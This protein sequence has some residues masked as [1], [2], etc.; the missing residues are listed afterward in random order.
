[1][2]HAEGQ[3]A[4][5]ENS[6]F[7]FITNYLNNMILQ[8]TVPKGATI[9][10]KV[11]V[12][13]FEVEPA[14]Q[15][16]PDASFSQLSQYTKTSDDEE[17]IYT[18]SLT[19]LTDESKQFVAISIQNLN[20]VTYYTIL[21][22]NNEEPKPI[23]YYNLAFNK[24][25]VLQEDAET[26]LY[27]N[28]ALNESITQDKIAF[29]ITVKKDELQKPSV[30]ISG[31]S[32][33]PDFNNLNNNLIT[34]KTDDEPELSEEENYN[35]NKFSID[36]IEGATY[37]LIKLDNTPSAQLSY[38]LVHVY[39]EDDKKDEE[40]PEEEEEKESG[41]EDEKESGKEEEKESGK[42]EEKEPG[43]EEEKEPGK[44]EK[45]EPGKEEEE[46][47]ENEEESEKE[48]EEPEKKEDNKT[49]EETP[50]GSGGWPIALIIVLCVVGG[51]VVL[52]II[53]FII[54]KICCKPK[55]VTSESIEGEFAISPKAS[56]E[57]Q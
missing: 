49:P 55:E 56:N 1:M 19:D 12:T 38:A 29:N 35:V 47:K 15:E 44:E 5:A 14:K 26:P 51:L 41:K 53:F 18:F 8:L 13:S 10:F 39:S 45:K 25:I 54:R 36:N 7:Y 20:P 4:I 57:L 32:E 27:F 43:K 30:T 2:N 48:S 17:D 11:G 52:I 34:A 3:D 37:L 23:K 22:K 33:A 28:V 50:S 42:E 31:Y 21:V 46:S 6:L 9:S 16:V 24:K 40:K